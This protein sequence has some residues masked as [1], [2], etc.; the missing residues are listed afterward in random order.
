MNPS[1]ESIQLSLNL[2]W[3]LLAGILVF[4]MQA[5]FTLLE[6][7]FTRAKHSISVAM[8]NVADIMVAILLFSTIGFPIM[9][10]DTVNGWFGTT[11][12]FSPA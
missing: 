11:G 1:A 6:A 7:G 12:F 9:F 5:G 2:A 3:I 8:K 4:V 10:G